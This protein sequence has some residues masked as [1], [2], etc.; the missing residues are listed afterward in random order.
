MAANGASFDDSTF[1]GP[2]DGSAVAHC[3]AEA[4]AGRQQA[5][6]EGAQR[7]LTAFAVEIVVGERPVVVAVAVVVGPSAFH[8]RA[9]AC[10]RDSVTAVDRHWAEEF[11]VVGALANLAVGV[12]HRVADSC[13][14]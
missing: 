3:R 8:C 10:C 13:R 12:S 4:G 1:P 11:A 9:F 7:L 14:A 6:F 2:F 5:T